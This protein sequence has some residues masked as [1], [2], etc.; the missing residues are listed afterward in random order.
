MKKITMPV[1]ATLFM[2]AFAMTLTQVNAMG[3]HDPKA[4]A[5]IDKIKGESGE[6]GET[7]TL[8]SFG[9]IGKDIKKAA[10]KVKDKVKHT[11]KD[12]EKEA[13]GVVGEG[14]MMLMGGGQQQMT[15]QQQQYQQQQVGE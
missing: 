12:V 2:F 10:K 6:S 9:D 14:A 11:A 5:M 4:Q 3:E 1:M 15:S 7:E 13:E 8:F